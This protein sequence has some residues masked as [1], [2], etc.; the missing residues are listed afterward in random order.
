[1]DTLQSDAPGEAGGF[2]TS[3]CRPRCGAS[4]DGSSTTP[5]RLLKNPSHASHSER[6]A[7]GSV[8]GA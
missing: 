3:T 4:G 1:M 8:G 7:G 5:N 2:L 6:S